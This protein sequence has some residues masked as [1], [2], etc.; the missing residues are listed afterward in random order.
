V[1]ADLPLETEKMWLEY[2]AMLEAVETEFGFEIEI[3]TSKREAE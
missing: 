1:G 3:Q 2:L